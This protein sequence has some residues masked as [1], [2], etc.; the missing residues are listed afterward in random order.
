MHV[1]QSHVTGDNEA[2]PVLR[3]TPFIHF[4][5]ARAACGVIMFI[6]VE[7]VVDAFAFFPAA[8]R[9]W[10]INASTRVVTATC[11]GATSSRRIATAIDL[12]YYS[13]DR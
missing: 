12:Q 8:L 4:L 9:V 2:Q 1:F 13:E 10:P 5:I 3:K 6:C 7:I 11:V